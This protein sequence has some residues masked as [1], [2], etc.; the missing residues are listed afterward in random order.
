MIAIG[1]E[2]GLGFQDVLISSICRCVLH[3]GRSAEFRIV[4]QKAKQE[5]GVISGMRAYCLSNVQKFEWRLQRYM[6]CYPY[7][8]LAGQSTTSGCIPGAI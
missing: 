8:R 4:S 1:L 5:F 7:E 6:G 2:L 3:I